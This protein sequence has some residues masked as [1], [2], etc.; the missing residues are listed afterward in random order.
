MIMTCKSKYFLFL[1]FAL[2]ALMCSCATEDLGEKANGKSPIQI[3]LMLV[4]VLLSAT[5][6]MRLLSPLLAKVRLQ[7]M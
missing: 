4:Q 2:T 1:S 7:A 5:A 3:I 6:F